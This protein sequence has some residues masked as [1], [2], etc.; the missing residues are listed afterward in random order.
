MVGIKYMT[1]PRCCQDCDLYV[2][3]FL[4]IK[5]MCMLTSCSAK[6][7]NNFNAK[8]QRMPNCRLEEIDLYGKK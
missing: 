3:E 1:M 6:H 4:T 7:L 2:E 5:K 8:T